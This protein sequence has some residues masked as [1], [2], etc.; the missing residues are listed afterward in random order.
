MRGHY[1]YRSYPRPSRRFDTQELPIS[2]FRRERQ[3]K[4]WKR[5]WKL[6]LIERSNPGWMDLIE[7]LQP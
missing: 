4:E 6:E 2:A 3:I 7:A 1:T 5:A